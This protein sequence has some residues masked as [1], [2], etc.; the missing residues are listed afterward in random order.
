MK[1]SY[2]ARLSAAFVSLKDFFV[3]VVICIKYS[4]C[5]QSQDKEARNK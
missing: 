1:V 4:A 5:Q 3:V 2:T